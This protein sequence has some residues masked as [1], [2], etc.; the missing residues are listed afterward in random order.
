MPE[1]PEVQTVVA[2]LKSTIIGKV[3]TNCYSSGQT[4]RGRK[5]VIEQE[6]IIGSLVTSCKRRAKYILIGL[7]NGHTLLI[8]L[9]MSGKILLSKKEL[10][11]DHLVL[12]FGDGD[13]LRFNDP[14]RFGVAK[15]IAANMVHQDPLLKNLGFE[16]LEPEFN[17]EALGAICQRRSAPIKSV[18]L[19]AN[20]VVGIGNIYASEALFEAG[21]LPIRAARTLKAA[22]LASLHAS[23]IRVLL[24]AIKS[25]GSTLRDYVH[26]GGDVGYFQHQFKVY[27]KHSKPCSVCELLIQK[28]VISN[29]STFYCRGCQ[30]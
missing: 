15:L 22:E 24:S 7:S 14:R 10:K 2:G 9:G 11:H 25:G 28:V 5:M 3:I 26:V 8:H 13:T 30:K 12:T 17:K 27:G 29:R 19:N 4:F 23:I 20:L 16:P 6:K 1:L 18:L 21:I